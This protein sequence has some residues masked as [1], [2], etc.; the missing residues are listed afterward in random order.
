MLTIAGVCGT[1]ICFI[2]LALVY[3]DGLFIFLED[4]SVNNMGRDLIYSYFTRRTTLE[5]SQLGWG[6]AGVAK[7]VENMDRSEVY[8]MA[9]VRGLHNDIMKIY[10]NFGFI[11]SLLWYAFNLIYIPREYFKKYGK[12]W[13]SYICRWHYIC[14]SHI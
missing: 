5:P 3:N 13:Q 10:I 2:Y 14:L 7:V 4:H 9:A 8:Y 12:K 1:C 11:G 6:M